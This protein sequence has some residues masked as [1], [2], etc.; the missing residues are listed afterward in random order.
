MLGSQQAQVETSILVIRKNREVTD[1]KK[2]SKSVWLWYPKCWGPPMELVLLL[3]EVE[4][5]EIVAWP[6]VSHCVAGDP[7]LP[8]LSLWK[9]SL[10]E[11]GQC[12]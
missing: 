10:E 6:C 5:G 4:G 12:L 9:V 1:P 7:V 8:V 3:R 2:V 11:K